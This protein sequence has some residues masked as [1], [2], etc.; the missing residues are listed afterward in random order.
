MRMERGEWVRGG[1]EVW[2]HEG[3]KEKKKS[4]LMGKECGQ[5]RKKS[6]DHGWSDHTG[7]G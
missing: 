2:S 6:D 3:E 7:V 5:G 1:S 4:R